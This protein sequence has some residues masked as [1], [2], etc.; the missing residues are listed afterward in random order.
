MGKT[1]SSFILANKSISKR[2][3]TNL[4]HAFDHIGKKETCAKFQR[5]LLNSMVVGARQGFQF[6]RQKTW[7]L[8]NDRGLP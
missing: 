8:G 5:K 7:F 1:R 4:K 6:F 3:K 2:N